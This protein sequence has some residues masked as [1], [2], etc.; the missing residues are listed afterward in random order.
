MKDDIIEFIKEN[1]PTLPVQIVGRIGGDSFVANAYLSELVERKD[2]LQSEERVGAVPLYYLP[3]QEELMKKKL[4]ELN[5][6]SKTPRTFQKKK[7]KE[8]PELESKRKDFDRRLRKIEAEESLRKDD[9]KKGALERARE[10][11]KKTVERP[12]TEMPKPRVEIPKPPIVEKPKPKGD[13]KLVD[14]EN[15]DEL[16]NLLHSEAK[17]I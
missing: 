3:G 15:I 11:I 12:Q 6:N 7:V 1:G 8:T 2:L 16:I 4:E 9:K 13:V 17:V 10:L 5:F 14:A